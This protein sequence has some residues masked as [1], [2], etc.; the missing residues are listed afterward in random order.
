M[1]EEFRQITAKAF[2]FVILMAAPLSV[3]FIF[4]AKDSI[5]LLSGK[6]YMGAVIPMQVIMPTVLL[7]GMTNIM[8]IQILVPMNREKV[9]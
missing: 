3:F 5:L 7:I 4:M 8:G 9:S 6:A 1:Q 2:N